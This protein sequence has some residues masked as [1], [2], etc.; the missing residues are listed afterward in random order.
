MEIKLIYLFLPMTFFFSFLQ[1]K[2]KEESSKNITFDL[3]MQFLLQATVSTQESFILH[4]IMSMDLNSTELIS[5]TYVSLLG[6]Q[7]P[8]NS[9]LIIFNISQTYNNLESVGLTLMQIKLYSD[10]IASKHHF[11]FYS[12]YIIFP[13]SKLKPDQTQRYLF[14][15]KLG[16][17]NG[18]YTKKFIRYSFYK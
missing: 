5:I 14:A 11:H 4:G 1:G 18:E 17:F 16:V 7:E 13:S 2:M 8:F 9:C 6:I 15:T 12:A 10:F 3:K